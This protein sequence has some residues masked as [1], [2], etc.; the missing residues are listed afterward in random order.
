MFPTLIAALWFTVLTTQL[1]SLPT[2]K[3]LA[4]HAFSMT[5]RYNN[6]FVSDVFRDNI[7]LTL[8]YLQGEIKQPGQV[9][10][11]M[12]EKPFTYS[13]TL[14]K[15][16][17]FAF[18]DSVLPQYKDKVNVTT[19]AHFNSLEG[20]KYDGDLVGDGVCH[21]ASLLSW[22]AKDAGLAVTTP[23]NHNFAQILEVPK[24]QG[25]AIYDSPTDQAGSA[26]QNLYITNNKNS[27]VSFMFTYDGSKLTIQVTEAT[28]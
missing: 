12:V 19:H 15:G 8:A 27:D 5:H 2:E 17:T 28:N 22:A 13:F 10:W 16:E 3:V 20:F 7:L 21:L 4:T 25:V 11:N 18:H 9:D 23:T 6:Q 24:E 26:L 1:P 14:K